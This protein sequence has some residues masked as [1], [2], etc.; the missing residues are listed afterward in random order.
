MRSNNGWTTLPVATSALMKITVGKHST[1]VRKGSSGYLLRWVARQI[2]ESVESCVTLYG[3]RSSAENR[4]ARGVTD[5][6]HLS[7]TA[8]DYNGGKHPYE[9]K[10]PAHAR[11]DNYNSGWS[12]ADV[13]AIHGILKAAGGLV[14]WGNDVSSRYRVGV[15]DAMHFEVRGS[16]AAVS[17]RVAKLSGGTVKVDVDS[18]HTL[19]GRKTPSTKGKALYERARGFKITYTSCV[20][21]EGRLWLRTRFGTYYAADLTTF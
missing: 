17:A 12:G 21:R 20:W 6:N 2:D 3:W 10:L 15:R 5:S 11:F 8:I 16:S 19:I 7:G 13:K 14:A 9:L 1:K 4:A 18:G